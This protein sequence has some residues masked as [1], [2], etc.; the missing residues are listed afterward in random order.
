MPIKIPL[1]LPA[2]E[3][4]EKENIFIMDDSRAAKQDIRPLNILILNLMPEKEK[5]ERQ[6][7]RLLGNTPLQ[8]NI[9]FLKTA[10]YD[11]KNTSQYHLEEFYQ[12]FNQVKEKKYDGMII[13]GAPIE[14]MEFEEVHYWD[15]L[16]EILDWT[17]RNVTS[18]LHI[19]WGA[20]AALYHHYGINKFVL[21]RK[22]SGV[23][24]HRVLDHTEKLLRGFDDEFIA[25]HSRNT[26]I[27]KEALQNH[28]Q[29][30]LLAS[31][32]EAGALIISSKDS[33]RI[34]ITGHL[35]YE[36]TTLAEEYLRDKEKGIEIVMPEN[37]FPQDNPD[38]KPANRW[39]S[40]AHLFF[41]NWLNYYVYQETPYEW[42]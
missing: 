19:C 14:L 3:I 21:A 28:P 12:T 34:M 42:D 36:A 11:A 5:T 22:C 26:D 13:T 41:S 27:S 6:L 15:E 23:F 24:T 30:K 40:H 29:L 31:S 33:R 18:T 7:L 10:T 1:H 25:P 32:D 38:K 9:T 35:E 8:V 39:R 2:K 4:L 16:K 17:E 37:Y 20:Q